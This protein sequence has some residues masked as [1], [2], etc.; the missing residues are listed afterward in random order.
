MKDYKRAYEQLDVQHQRLL[1]VL[2]TSIREY[3][4]MAAQYAAGG[5]DMLAAQYRHQANGVREVCLSMGMEV[6]RC[7]QQQ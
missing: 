7:E 4:R 3:E 2:Y 6:E 1:T 5:D